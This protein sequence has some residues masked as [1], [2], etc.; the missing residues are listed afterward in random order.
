MELN[1]IDTDIIII[2]YIISILTNYIPE[3]LLNPVSNI[4]VIQPGSFEFPIV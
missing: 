3:T 2:N 1:K 4:I